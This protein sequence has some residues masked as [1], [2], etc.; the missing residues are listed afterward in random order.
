[1]RKAKDKANFFMKKTFLRAVLAGICVSLGGAVF[2]SVENMVAGAFLFSI[3]LFTILGFGFD[4]FTGKVG[5]IF[6]N[7]PSY[8]GTLGV[9][10]LG[11][12]AGTGLFALMLRFTKVYAGISGRIGTLVSGK[13]NDTPVSVFLLATGCGLCMYI[14]VQSY[15][16]HQDFQK[17]IMVVLPIMAFILARF[18]HCIA[19][20]FYFWLYWFGC[21][22]T[23]KSLVYIVIM[24]L[25]NS[26]GALIIPGALKLFE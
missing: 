21:G 9:I 20:M 18:E 14:A 8:L 10:W 23:L 11:N 6:E 22:F 19:N 2:L 15:R 16:T 7:K 26:V 3:G 13:L 12:L 24:S 17:I 25:G 5:Y 1:M 4:L